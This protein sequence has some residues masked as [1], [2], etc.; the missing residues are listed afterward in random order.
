MKTIMWRT[1]LLL[2]LVAGCSSG[3]GDSDGGLPDG[4]DGGDGDGYVVTCSQEDVYCIV[5]EAG[6]QACGVFQ[7]NRPW[8]VELSNLA[9][10]HFKPGETLLPE[11]LTDMEAGLVDRVEFGPDATALTPVGPGLITRTFNPVPNPPDSGYQTYEY[12][13]SFLGGPEELTLSMHTDF[14]VEGGVPQRRGTRI[15][16]RF[17]QYMYLTSWLGVDPNDTLKRQVYDSCD[18]S[19]YTQYIIT[20]EAQSGDRVVFHK[21]MYSP[22]IVGGS[23]PANLESAQATVDGTTRSTTDYFD[24]VYSAVHHNWD[25]GYTVILR[26]PVGDVLGL[27]LVDAGLNDDPV[28]MLYLGSDLTRIRT[29]P[30]TSYSEVKQ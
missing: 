22:D 8:S 10:V 14:W 4:S 6:A 27:V 21:R 5:I 19:H 11:D 18:Y 23:M 16:A 28:E 25:E 2:L 9:R 17:S 24:L 1:A 20:A 7:D 12:V 29:S 13:Q 3:G 30:L 26:P 15:G